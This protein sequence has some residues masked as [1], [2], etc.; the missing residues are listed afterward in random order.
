MEQ[1]RVDRLEARWSAFEG[2]DPS[3]TIKSLDELHMASEVL[4]WC[5]LHDIP[6]ISKSE[7]YRAFPYHRQRE[8]IFKKLAKR[9]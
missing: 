7:L 1:E 4:S 8:A 9:W 5:R 6:A 2:R 3:T